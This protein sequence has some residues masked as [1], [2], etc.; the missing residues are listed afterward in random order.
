MRERFPC[1][2]KGNIRR[3]LCLWGFRHPSLTK[4]GI[5]GIRTTANCFAVC[6]SCLVLEPSSCHFTRTH[7]VTCQRRQRKQKQPNN[8]RTKQ[9][10]KR[11]HFGSSHRVPRG[12]LSQSGLFSSR[13]CQVVAK[14]F[15]C[16]MAAHRLQDCHK[17]RDGSVDPA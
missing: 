4:S 11:S 3:A 7:R 14:S 8:Q 17:A 5:S 15:V 12:F 2:V 6:A 9:T 10:N 16:S 13:L 1:S